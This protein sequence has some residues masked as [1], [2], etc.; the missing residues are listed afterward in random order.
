MHSPLT[1]DYSRA[2]VTGGGG[3]RPT[4]EDV[5][6]IYSKRS[7]PEESHEWDL[8]FDELIK[9]HKKSPITSKIIPLS[10]KDKHNYIAICDALHIDPSTYYK[11][12]QVALEQAAIIAIKNNIFEPA[13]VQ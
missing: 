8:V 3:V 11:Y 7:E 4:D 13:Q 6:A 12:R 10:F 1:K 9:A 5:E 2:K